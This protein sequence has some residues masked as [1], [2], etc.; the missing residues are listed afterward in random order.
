MALS[1]SIVPV[2]V[3]RFPEIQELAYAIWP[4]HYQSIISMEQIEFML[5]CLYSPEALKEAMEKG[6]QQFFIAEE[7][8]KAVGFLGLTPHTGRR[9]K[10]DKL[11]L[12][13]E[14]RGK[15]YG[16]KMIAFALARARELDCHTL[17][18]NVN[19]YNEAVGF[20]KSQGF[21]MLEQIDIPYG[22]FWL[23]DYVMEKTVAL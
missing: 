2:S 15:G 23:N 20:Y 16:N 17:Y 4:V 18:L 22:P 3:S 6:G 19:R 21:R 9:L 14:C 5:R 8:G 12:T 10:L 11:Y 7:S 13:L 1:F